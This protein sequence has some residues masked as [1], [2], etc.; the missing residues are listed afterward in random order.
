LAKRVMNPSYGCR[1]EIRKIEEAIADLGGAAALD[2]PTDAG[3][4]V[5]Y[6]YCLFK[7]ASI[8]GD[9]AAFDEV[10]RAIRLAIPLLACPGDLFL[11]KANVAFKLHRLVDAEAALTADPFVHHSVEGRLLRAD[12]DFQ[13]GRYRQARDAYCEVLAV[14]RSWGALARLAH[15]TGKMDDAVS[16]D[17]LYEEAQDELTA[18]ELCS[19]A[20]LEVQRGFLDFAHGR[21]SEARSHYQRADRAYPGYW[22][23]DEHI[24]ELLGAEKRYAE[25]IAILVRLASSGS[26]PDLEQAIGEL[27]NLTGDTKQ[28]EQWSRKALAS[29][30]LS[31]ER[32]QVCFWHHLAD[33]YIEVA[34]DGSKA[35]AWAGKDVELREN[36]WTQAALAR[37][38]CCDRRFAEARDWIDR[39]LGSGVVDARLFSQAGSIYSATGNNALGQ[40]CLDRAMRLNPMIDRFHLHH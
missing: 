4:V 6:V 8:A 37:A 2:P 9:L 26:R 24:A 35:V 11:L 15:L 19:F 36:F 33:F 40:A 12:L 28:A 10:E 39:A 38:L 29:Y 27:Y 21:F 31:A 32:G 13:R 16:A 14:E 7:K 23:T 20:W 17:R 34:R 22:L 30:Q 3:R 18:K 25:A 1:A 5:R